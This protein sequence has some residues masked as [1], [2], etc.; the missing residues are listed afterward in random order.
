MKILDFLK[1][2]TKYNQSGSVSQKSLFEKY[3]DLTP[4]VRSEILEG[5]RGKEFVRVDANFFADMIEEIKNNPM[6]S[7]VTY[8]NN[9]IKDGSLTPSY[10]SV[11]KKKFDEK[12]LNL[13]EN[14][15]LSSKI[16]NAMGVP[17]VYNAKFAINN[18]NFL[19]SVDFLE[20]GSKIINIEDWRNELSETLDIHMDNSRFAKEV[21]EME[22][23]ISLH[24]LMDKN[25]QWK[26]DKTFR[27]DY[28]KYY[29]TRNII[30]GD[31]DSYPRNVCFVVDKDNNLSIGPLYDTECAFSDASKN[32][33]DIIFAMK[34]LSSSFEEFNEKYKNLISKQSLK[35][36]FRGFD[37]NFVLNR[38]KYMKEC[39]NQYKEICNKAK[40][41]LELDYE[42]Y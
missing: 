28:L 40:E 35:E 32:V 15:I 18:E 5:H 29:L 37:K 10:I 1:K 21:L 16:A 3:D 4:R 27:S 2:K 13:L 24:N 22:E 12:E 6:C 34:Y 26:V 23:I 42:R 19:L 31:T 39:Y 33:Y 9:L 17:T 14:E 38:C 20:Y 41:M 30:L 25:N 36:I 8:L 7:Y 11:L